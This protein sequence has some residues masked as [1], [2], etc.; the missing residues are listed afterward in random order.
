[1]GALLRTESLSKS[2]GGLRAV[3]NVN[4]S[5]NEGELR[6]IIG[7]NGA[8]KSTF[9]N[10]LSSYFRSDA[11]RILWRDRDITHLR[12]VE[13]TCLGIARVF[14]RTNTFLNLTVWENAMLPLL[15]VHKQGWQMLTPV[16]RLNRREVEELVEEVGLL[17]RIDHIASTLSHGDQRRLELAIALAN[18]PALLLLDEPTAGMSVSECTEMMTLLLRLNQKRGLTILLT[19][20]DM[21]V[22]FSVS[23][24]ITVLHFGRIIAEGSPEEIRNNEE[25]Q[26]VYLGGNA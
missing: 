8:G 3:D 22:V 25:V 7:S 13:I 24:R 23:Q 5:V 16:S 26:T 1:M 11:G 18:R 12:R 9:F 15:R 10:L 21:K 2:F 6:S 20:H 19:E 14:Q 4:F 17:E